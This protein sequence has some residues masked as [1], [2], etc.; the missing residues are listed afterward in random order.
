MIK[1]KIRLDSLIASNLYFFLPFSF[2]LLVGFY[3]GVMQD[4]AP[5]MLLINQSNS[6]YLDKFFIVM[7]SL[8]DGLFSLIVLIPLL[9]IRLRFALLL[10]VCYLGSGLIV[11]ISKRIFQTPCPKA[12]F[13]GTELLHF[14]DGVDV[15]SHNSFPSGHTASAFALFLLLALFI[16]NKKLGI[17]FFLMAF[18]VGYSRIYLAQHFVVDVYFGAIFG[19]VFT[20]FAYITMS[21]YFDSKHDTFWFNKPLFKLFHKKNN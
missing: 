16:K 15:F 17:V 5:L 2:F 13:D 1:N 10:L 8:G 21:N 4:K 14:A 6:V 18:L 19:V 7:T 3:F 20:L 9:I 12:Y 11:Q